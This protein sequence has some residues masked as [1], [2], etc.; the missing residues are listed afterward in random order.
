MP[1]AS[2]NVARVKR[3]DVGSYS[4]S[5]L[6]PLPEGAAGLVFVQPFH[7][8]VFGGGAWPIPV[9][10]SGAQVSQ[11]RVQVLCW[12]GRLQ[13]VDPAIVQFRLD[14]IVPVRQELRQA[15]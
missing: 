15:E 1:G 13:P 4:V 9:V 5:L 12:D 11:D 10:C 3:L 8:V 2:S 14:A 7:A 6:A